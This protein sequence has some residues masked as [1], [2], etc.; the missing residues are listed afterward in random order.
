MIINEL[1]R[2]WKIVI[3][4]LRYCLGIC[5]GILRKT[6]IAGFEAKIKTSGLP[7]TK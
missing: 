2:L 5:L 6:M 3:A 7:G 1:E 4:K